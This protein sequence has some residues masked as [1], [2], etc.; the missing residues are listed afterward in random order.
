MALL[1]VSA[2]LL[3]SL[4][5]CRS[6]DSTSKV[7]AT[8]VEAEGVAP[9]V[10]TFRDATSALGVA[11]VYENDAPAGRNAIVESLGG[12]VAVADVDRDGRQDLLFAGGGRFDGD[13]LVGLPTALF[14][15]I[16]DGVFHEITA[17]AGLNSAGHY[18]H[19]LA[20]ADAD[21]DGFIESARSTAPL[22]RVS[23]FARSYA[24]R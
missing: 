14:R 9:L 22:I 7:P 20:A 1:I 10:A 2:S 8:F 3:I 21:N 16:G 23:D 15:R 19:G 24:D 18:S 17:P 4:A 5:G 13:K 11:H 6:R 12:V